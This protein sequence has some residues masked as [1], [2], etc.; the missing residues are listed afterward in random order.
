MIAMTTLLLAWLD[1]NALFVAVMTL[2]GLRR[3]G[4]CA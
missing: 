4:R 2:L 3:S 1:L